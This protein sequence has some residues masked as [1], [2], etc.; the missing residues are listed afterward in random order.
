MMKIDYFI[1]DSKNE[2]QQFQ[3]S[4]DIKARPLKEKE[5]PLQETRF[6]Q[7]VWK[8]WNMNISQLL[9]DYLKPK[10]IK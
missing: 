2:I 4:T 10:K 7:T 1:S 9:F 5:K 6:L 3:N 8:V